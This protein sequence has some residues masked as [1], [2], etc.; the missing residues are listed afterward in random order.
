ML[1]YLKQLYTDRN[2]YNDK[3]QRR[4]VE[5]SYGWLVT[6]FSSSQVY[7]KLS[8]TVNQLKFTI[9]LQDAS[10]LRILLLL[11]GDIQM[12][13]RS[14]VYGTSQSGMAKGNSTQIQNADLKNCSDKVN[15]WI[16]QTKS[17][18]QNNDTGRR[19]VVSP[20]L[21]QRSYWFARADH[22]QSKC[23]KNG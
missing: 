18:W 3:F 1:K 12:W 20:P 16:Q 19:P 2:S 10:F 22:T 7:I 6:H 21:Q 13:F 17:S 8:Y 11:H 4:Q 9:C 23:S 14:S 5:S 15:A